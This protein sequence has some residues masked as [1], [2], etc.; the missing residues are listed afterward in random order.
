MAEGWS[1]RRAPERAGVGEHFFDSIF[2]SSPRVE[3]S[4]QDEPAAVDAPAEPPDAADQP[5]EVL[6]IAE[7]P[8]VEAE[9]SPPAGR[10][11]RTP[12]RPSFH[13]TS[14]A[15]IAVVATAMVFVLWYLVL[16]RNATM[17][18]ES[19]P[20]NA[21][22]LVT[23]PVAGDA[24][25]DGGG[26][27]LDPSGPPS[28]GDARE[29]KAAVT[30]LHRLSRSD[31]ASL[32]FDGRYVA[33]LAS[34]WDGITDPLQVDDRGSHTFRAAAILAEHRELRASLQPT[35]VRLLD[36]TTFG[37]HRHYHGTPYWMTVATDPSFRTPEAVRAWCTR[38]F[39][40]LPQDQ[41]KN[42]CIPMQ[43]TR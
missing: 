4:R 19:V 40:S 1:E 42:R 27:S 12:R 20:A 41:L 21:P 13:P 22:G 3:P 14:V 35:P 34:K 9:P 38:Q 6:A 30:E 33:R 25:P 26:A 18:V 15:A 36:S 16:G 5:T 28:P 11:S 31:M 29:E 7:P 2:R 10:P 43:L 17:T 37:T 8:A 32:T 23:A 24:A 39:P